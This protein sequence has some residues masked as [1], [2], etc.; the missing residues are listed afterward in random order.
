MSMQNEQDGER[1]FETGMDEAYKLTMTSVG[2]N[3]QAH[4]DALMSHAQSNFDADVEQRRR[5]VEDIHEA[6]MRRGDIAVDR[7]WNLDEQIQALMKN[8]VFQD[9]IAAAVAIAVQSHSH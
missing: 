3:R 4:F 8:V 1:E 6:K 7:Q 9:A 5:H 2:S